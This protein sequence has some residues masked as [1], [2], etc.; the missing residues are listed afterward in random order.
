MAAPYN[1][2]KKG[3]DFKFAV[4]LSDANSPSRLKSAPTLAAGDVKVKK[5]FGAAA[6]IATLP[7][8]DGKEVSVTLSAT[9]MTADNVTVIFSDVNDPPEWADLIVHIPTT[10]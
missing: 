8:A 6:N 1:P 10:A 2:P 5:D 4:G 7:T 9:E 3:E